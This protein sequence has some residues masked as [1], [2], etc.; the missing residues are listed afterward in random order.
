[1]NDT[2]RLDK[3]GQMDGYGLISDDNGHWACVTEGTQNCPFG[4]GPHDIHTTFWIGKDR[5]FDT[6]REAI[7][8]AVMEYA[9]DE[10]QPDFEG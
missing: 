2:E 1:M 6:I 9:E 10:T 3:L 7:D 8:H 4:G 5:W